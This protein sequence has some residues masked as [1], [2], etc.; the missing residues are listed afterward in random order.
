MMIPPSS[1][2][3]LGSGTRARDD[4]PSTGA[5]MGAHRPGAGSLCPGPPGLPRNANTNSCCNV[6]GG[7]N[8]SP[9][10]AG[11]AIPPARLQRWR[12]GLLI[13]C[14]LCSLGL[15]HASCCLGIEAA[16]FGSSASPGRAPHACLVAPALGLPCA[17]PGAQPGSQPGAQ[18]GGQVGCRA[19][20]AAAYNCA[21]AVS[22]P[23]SIE[24]PPTQNKRTHPRH[25]RR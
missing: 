21:C 1:P 11:P 5:R 24:T 8:H 7:R 4:I 23:G 22:S 9:G 25:D 3:P 14:S 16:A 18:P 17:Q 6:R 2:S 10:P 20:R 15:S 19:A 13:S 12:G